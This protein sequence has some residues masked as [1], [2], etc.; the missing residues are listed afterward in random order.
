MIPFAM[1]SYDNGQNAAKVNICLLRTCMIFLNVYLSELNDTTD[2]QW[3][4]L[5]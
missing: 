2:S 4:Y 3:L 5:W 1:C